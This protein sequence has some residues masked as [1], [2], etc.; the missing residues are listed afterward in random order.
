MAYDLEDIG[1][2]VMDEDVIVILTMGLGT[3]YDHFVASIDAMLTQQLM[4]DYVVTR[5]LNEEARSREKGS[6]YRNGALMAKL[7][8]GADR[9]A[10][11]RKCWRCGETDHVC[12]ECNVLS[13][14]KC[15]NCRGRGHTMKACLKPRGA[16]GSSETMATILFAF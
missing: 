16:E 12:S 5:M 3:K 1:R 8:A 15:G 14:M 6:T 7:Q 11:V 13:D 10:G 9:K 2:T 4:V